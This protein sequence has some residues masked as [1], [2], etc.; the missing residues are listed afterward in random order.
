[1]CHLT[2][3]QW[4]SQGHSNARR[5]SEQCRR[6]VKPLEPRL[7][8]EKRKAHAQRWNQSTMQLRLP[9]E[10]LNETLKQWRAKI[11]CRKRDLL[12]LIGVLSHACKVVRPG[13][14]FLLDLGKVPKHLDHFVRLN[15]EARSDLHRMVVPLCG[16]VE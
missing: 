8:Q 1:M 12:S 7:T 2:L 16:T 10:K 3:S 15:E 9:R 13:R 6:R 11:C 4:E 5:I 14:S